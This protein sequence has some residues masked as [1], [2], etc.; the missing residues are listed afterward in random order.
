MTELEEIRQ[1]TPLL[2][3]L[4]ISMI[5]NH[6]LFQGNGNI[7]EMD[8][9]FQDGD[10][11]G[12]VRAVMKEGD[13]YPIHRH[14]NSVEILVVYKGELLVSIG[15]ETISIKPGEVYRIDKD[16]PHIAKAKELTIVIGLTIPCDDSY[17]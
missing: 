4:F 15:K 10:G 7:N 9:I 13:K 6:R 5:D 3:E 8:S 2:K 11:V 16:T 17:K 1:A 14:K 12:I